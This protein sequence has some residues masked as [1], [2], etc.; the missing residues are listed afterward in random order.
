[1]APERR[2]KPEQ[3][4]SPRG[5]PGRGVPA[6]KRSKSGNRVRSDRRSP[7]GKSGRGAGGAPGGSGGRNARR[8]GGGTAR[9]PGGKRPQPAGRKKAG[10]GRPGRKPARATG[11][12]PARGGKPP[13]RR[14]GQGTR[15]RPNRGPERK[16]PHS[17]VGPDNLPRWMR[18]EIRRATHSDRQAAVLRVFAE[19]VDSFAKDEFGAAWRKL[20]EAKNLSPRSSA[21][22]ELM[23][24]SAYRLGKWREALAELRAYRRFTGDT[25]HMPVE[26]DVLRALERDFDV[27]KTWV[28]FRE[29]GGNRPTEAEARVVFGSYLLDQGRADEAWEVTAP[30]RL[31]RDARPYELR[32]WFVAARSALARDEVETA[33]KLATAIGRMD[34]ELPGLAEL[35]SDISSGRGRRG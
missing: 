18:E 16:A 17:G 7:T 29:L 35:M 34:S 21:V 2:R 11:S 1:M 20:Y 4:R 30:S 19:A 25:T 28:R 32:V 10:T 13:S 27:E 3:K 33:G 31:P 8:T 24:L 5:A 15:R 22:R 12:R 23:G 26:M 9:R 14:S 6:R